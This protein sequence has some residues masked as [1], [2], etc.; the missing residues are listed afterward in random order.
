ML[1][2]YCGQTKTNVAPAAWNAWMMLLIVDSFSALDL[3]L[4]L[5]ALVAGK[6]VSC[7]LPLPALPAAADAAMDADGRALTV[8]SC[9]R[10]GV[11]GWPG[12]RGGTCRS[13]RHLSSS[14]GQLRGNSGAAH[15]H[16]RSSGRGGGVSASGQTGSG[17]V[18]AVPSTDWS[19]QQQNDDL[20]SRLCGFSS[21]F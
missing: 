20:R 18:S 17:K 9:G 5:K 19:S 2:V 1:W 8:P 11:G 15:S 10:W 4:P 3:R 6:S 7:I 21:T 12:G 14:T 16:A 13:H